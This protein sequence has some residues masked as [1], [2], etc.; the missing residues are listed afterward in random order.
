MNRETQDDRERE[1]Q[2]QKE[3]DSDRETKGV[4]EGGGG[5]VYQ[6][7]KGRGELG[8]AEQAWPV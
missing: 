8:R 7:D 3:K 4:G 6:R 5:C 1:M 2:K